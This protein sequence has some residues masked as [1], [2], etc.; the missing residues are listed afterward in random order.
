[1]AETLL[2]ARLTFGG[3]GPSL[4]P[5]DLLPFLE[6]RYPDLPREGLKVEIVADPWVPAGDVLGA[7][8]AVR[9]WGAP[10]V[11]FRGTQIFRGD[12]LERAVAGVPLRAGGLGMTVAGTRVEPR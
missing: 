2:S 7:V 4:A 9:R 3:D 11:I 10:S 6:A 1:M 12:T 8:D 5:K